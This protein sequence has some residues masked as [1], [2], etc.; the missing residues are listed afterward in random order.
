M[1]L[2]SFCFSRHNATDINDH[3]LSK[4]SFA[5]ISPLLDSY[6]CFL[7]PP[8]KMMHSFCNIDFLSVK[9]WPKFHSSM[10]R[11]YSRSQNP[12]TIHKSSAVS[13][14]VTALFARLQWHVLHVSLL[15]SVSWD[16][17]FTSAEWHYW[18]TYMIHD[19]PKEGE[20]CRLNFSRQRSFVICM[21][22]PCL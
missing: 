14:Q 22:P 5:N 1:L 15:F 7:S 13:S 9:R 8:T 2:F 6:K 16:F 4:T 19:M 20:S 17:A 18:D 21:S 11:W 3:R 12:L 10:Y